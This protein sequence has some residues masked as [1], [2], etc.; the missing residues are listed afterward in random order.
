MAS[1]TRW[2]AFLG[3]I[4]VGGHR[5]T[6]DRLR[7]QFEALKLSNVS[8]FIASGNVIFEAA[9]EAHDLETKIQMRLERALGYAVPTFVRAAPAVI[10]AA[11]REPFDVVADGD[12]HLVAILRLPPTSAAKKA[13]LALSTA[14]DTFAAHGAELHWRIHGKSMDSEVQVKI[15]SKT[16]LQPF[17]IRNA[18]SLRKLAA[19]LR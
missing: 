5:V 19:T 9:L 2:V 3:G 13:T 17:T 11:A 4:N 16:I 12:T 1:M 8:T 14:R 7:T 15:L 18:K 6:M 10:A